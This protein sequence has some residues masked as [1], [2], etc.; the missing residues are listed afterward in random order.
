MSIDKVFELATSVLAANYKVS[1]AEVELLGLF[2]TSFALQV[3]KFCT[4][5]NLIERIADEFARAGLMACN[6]KP[7]VDEMGGSHGQ[8]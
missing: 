6:V 5:Q 7:D 2:D 8:G 4:H 1:L 3:L